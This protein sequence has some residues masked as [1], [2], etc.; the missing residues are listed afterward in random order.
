MFAGTGLGEVQLGL[1]ASGIG[2]STEWII[3]T[4]QRQPNGDYGDWSQTARV[5]VGTV[6]HRLA[7]SPGESYQI[8]VVGNQGGRFVSNV[9]V[10]PYQGMMIQ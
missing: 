6:N 2:G 5:P 4:R 8:Q 3:S 10:P 9:A 7:L 1:P